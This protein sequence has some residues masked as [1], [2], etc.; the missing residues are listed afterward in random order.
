MHVQRLRTKLGDAEADRD[1]ARLGLSVQGN[2]AESA[3]GDL[4]HPAGRGHVAGAG[5]RGGGPPLRGGAPLRRDLVGDIEQSLESE[6]ELIGATT[7]DSIE[8]SESVRRLA[9]NQRNRRITL[10]DSTGRVRADDFLPARCP[11]SRITSTGRK[12]AR[13]SKAVSGSPPATAR[14]WAVRCCTSPSPAGHDPSPRTC[15]R[16]TTS[17]AGRRRPVVGAALFA[18][19]V[20]A[21]LALVAGRSIA[22]R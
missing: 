13:H 17:C 18:L 20:G 22:G 21:L 9:A 11:R 3:P 19:L 10:V 14:R 16:W 1:G 8:W 12:S 15:G 6:A 4:R 7:A 2:G 5:A